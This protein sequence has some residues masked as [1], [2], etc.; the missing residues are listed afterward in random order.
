MTNKLTLQTL[1]SFLWETAD[2]LRGNM[3]ASEFKDYIFGM[4]FLK[5]LSDAFDEEREKVVQYYLDKGKTQAQAEELS[6]D[7]DEYDDTFFMPAIARWSALKDLKHN[8]GEALN[9]AAEAIEEHNSSLEGVLVTI[10]F[11]IKNKLSD[12]KLQDLLSH[13]SQ[14]RLRNA[15]FERPDMLGTAYEYL[16]K[17]FAD[18][19]GKKGGEFYTPSE[20][21]QLLVALLKPHAG[22][23]IYDPTSGSGGM[24]VQMRNHLAAH[25]ENAANLSLF[26]QEMNLNTW[27]ICKMNMFLHGVHNADIRKGD[28]LRDP[29][30][31]L[32]GELMHFDRVIAN[33]PFS[34][35]KWGKED[36][37]NDGFG[38]FPYGT[39]PKDAGDLAFVQHMIASTN[40]DG[41]VGVVMPHGVLFR[42]S[43]EKAIRQ[44]IL[45]DD[46]LEAVVGLPAGLFYGTG[47]PACLLII[48]KQK[49]A[50]RKGKVLFINSELE[51]QEGKNQNKLREQDIA[52]IVDTFDNYTELSRY[53]KVVELSEI[54]DNDYNLNI[55]RY[56]DTSPPAEI[57]DVRAIL[58]GGIPVREV[59]DAYIRDEILKGFDVSCVFTPRYSLEGGNPQSVDYYDFKAEIDTKEKIRPI[60]EKSFE[61][62]LVTADV[63]ATG[64]ESATA[65][66]LGQ[67]ERW[68]DKY[69]VSMHQL[70]VEV[71]A[72]EKVM[73]GYLKELGYDV[74]DAQVPRA[75]GC[76]GAAE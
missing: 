75:N 7:E 63:D 35:S 43:S 27:A 76:A 28:T 29:K 4:M 60:V 9:T 37:D 45:E 59:E 21:V 38:R 11:N 16:I 24:L 1:E 25:G 49:P 42:G 39:P 64:Q 67:L 6:D 55:R 74:Q 57:F 51:Y 46:L 73:Q 56:A 72:A 23:R 54:A 47:I 44:G 20:V 33:P 26:G 65:L 18:S 58:H 61:A 71:A 70:D 34:L 31:T 15:D 22:M 8:I 50:D 40:N 36:C 10:D 3:D 41:M 5:R 48:N 13:F 68:W 30:H 52:K 14:H 2:I 19:A 53:S 12:K 32:G 62:S 69:H 66:V 17:M